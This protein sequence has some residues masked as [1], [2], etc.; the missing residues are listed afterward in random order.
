M[1]SF[2]LK[3]LYFILTFA[4]FYLAKII[5]R[6]PWFKKMPPII[7]SSIIIIF[8][9][10]WLNI[11]FEEYNSGAKYITF[12][13]G[14]ATIALAYPLI[15]NKEILLQN[16][17]AIYFGFIFATFIAI[18]SAAFLG[19]IFHT[20]FSVLL[21]MLPKSVTTPI[22]VEISKTIGGIPELTACAVIFTGILGAIFGRRILK[23]CGIKNDIAIGLSVG[24]SSHV[25]G[26]SSL[27]ERKEYRQVAISTVALTIVA[28]LTA[29]LAPILIKLYHYLATALEI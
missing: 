23:I 3:I 6:F 13:L 11:S 2:I 20:K 17:R 28:I 27:A 22:A 7:L 21:S 1:F 24:A 9:L 15:K 12:L 5:T 18:L 19:K 14:P 25:M 4:F 8:L 26:T 16:K 10:K 29:I